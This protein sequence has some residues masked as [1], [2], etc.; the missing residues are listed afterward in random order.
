M[1]EEALGMK[2]PNVA[3]T[4]NNLAWLYKEQGRYAEAKQL[5]KRACNH[6][7]GPSLW[8]V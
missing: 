3:E 6:G 4:L 7:S 2:H 5:S 8:M 1:F